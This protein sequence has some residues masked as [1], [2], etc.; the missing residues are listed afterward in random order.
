M[1]K[2][3]AR[4]ILYALVAVIFLVVATPFLPTSIFI[5]PISL[6]VENG[7]L[8]YVRKVRFPMVAKHQT[9]V[10]QGREIFPECN[11]SGRTLFERRL[12]LEPVEWRF[13]CTLPDGEY[14]VE[15]CA[16][17]TFFAL[18]MRPACLVS[19]WLVG[20]PPDLADQIKTI[21]KQL[22]ALQSEVQKK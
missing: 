2:S 13:P 4:S 1:T 3:I 10:T 17:A 21:Q 22:D 14:K 16:T 9:E 7:R 18:D 5:N 6:T 8:E 19:T 20:N 12:N 11:A 15:V